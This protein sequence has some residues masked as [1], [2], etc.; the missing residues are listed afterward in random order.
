[1]PTAH[2]NVVPNHH[3]ES[4]FRERHVEVAAVPRIGEHLVLEDHEGKARVLRV[5][6]VL[7]PGN[8]GPNTATVELVLRYVGT[9]SD[10]LGAIQEQSFPY[11]A[12]VVTHVEDAIHELRVAAFRTEVEGRVVPPDALYSHMEREG[13]PALAFLR[14]LGGDPYQRLKPMVRD[15][16]R[17]LAEEPPR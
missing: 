14:T 2:L 7:H 16:E 9:E 6:D 12:W 15:Y 8:P 13:S 3:Y 11:P 5:L 10:H 4:F 17:K 1:M